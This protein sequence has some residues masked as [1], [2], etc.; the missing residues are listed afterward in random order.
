MTASAPDRIVI[1]R[2]GGI[3]L[4]SVVSA[5]AL[6]LLGDALLRGAGALVALAA[7]WLG[8]I[9][10]LAWWLLASPAVA[11]T[12]DGLENIGPLRRR[13]VPWAEITALTARFSLDVHT[14][15][16]RTLRFGSAPSTGIDRS[17][18]FARSR[19]ER[20]RE[21]TAALIETARDELRARSTAAASSSHTA[22][23]RLRGREI[24]VTLGLLSWGIVAAIAS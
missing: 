11:V 20:R 4:A 12:A 17:V 7:P 10:W 6:Y 13:F 1:R 9:V 15:D 5:F 16:G 22:R 19:E 21:N 2:R 23:P 14:R 3:I 18:G 24:L 8:L